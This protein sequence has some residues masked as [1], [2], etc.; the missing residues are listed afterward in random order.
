[1]FGAGLWL[2]ISTTRAKDRVGL[3]A[4]WA[5]MSFLVLG[6][7]ASL[8]AGAPAS[9]TA[10]AWGALTMWLIVPWGWWA[11]KHREFRRPLPG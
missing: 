2:Y 11:D 4:F 7:M 8:F 9:T 3:Y 10:L 6:Y 1:V 5:L